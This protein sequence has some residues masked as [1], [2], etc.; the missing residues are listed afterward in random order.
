LRTFAKCFVVGSGAKTLLNVL[1][2]VAFRRGRGRA[3]TPR[4]L[5]HA[6]LD[7]RY[8]LFLGTYSATW[9]LVSCLARTALL[10]APSQPP[11]AHQHHQQHGVAAKGEDED[12]DH[13]SHHHHCQQQQ[14]Q[15]QHGPSSSS[16][17]SSDAPSVASSGSEVAALP[18][19]LA[20]PCSSL[21]LT[22]SAA[23]LEGADGDEGEEEEEEAESQRS[24]HH[25]HHQGGGGG[26]E[27]RE[28]TVAMTAAAAAAAARDRYAMWA[29]DVAAGAASG[30]ALYWLPKSDR[31]GL[32]LYFFTRS[33]EFLAR[34]LSSHR[35]LPPLLE[36]L[37]PHVDVA[38]MALSGELPLHHHPL[39]PPPS[40][41]TPLMAG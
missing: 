16:G 12:E 33:G 35:L 8:G 37:A 10:A 30:L 40:P 9:K 4:L 21:A 22:S 18:G 2:F 29:I 27:G 38:L 23:S 34:F 17:G 41:K 26:G 6:L 28:A 24:E 14:Q 31:K 13:H 20:R 19:S 36:R 7:V 11:R 3:L 15:Q 1:V 5:L 25:H 32:A 39:H